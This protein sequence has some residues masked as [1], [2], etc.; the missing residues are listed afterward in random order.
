MCAHLGAFLTYKVWF[1]NA[2][3]LLTYKVW[4]ENAA[5]LALEVLLMC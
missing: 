3:A 5:A 2:A 1:E 4:F